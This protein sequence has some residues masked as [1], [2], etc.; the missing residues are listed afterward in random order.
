MAVFAQVAPIDI[1]QMVTQFSSVGFAVWFA[2]YT[3]TK[4]V[5]DLVKDFR[6][7]I[8]EQRESFLKHLDLLSS[9]FGSVADAAKACDCGIA[10]GVERAAVAEA[11]RIG[12]AGAC[13]N[14]AP[15]QQAAF[16]RQGAGT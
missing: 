13:L 4:L 16:V 8:K 2:Y 6:S 14:V 15:G 7:D 10:A 12:A 1:A 9:T 3:V 5:P 11:D